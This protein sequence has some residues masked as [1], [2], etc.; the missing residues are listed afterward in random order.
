MNSHPAPGPAE[1]TSTPGPESAVG[2]DQPTLHE[3]L[4]RL[5]GD[6]AARSAFDADP[7]GVLNQ[8]G[9]G[10][11]SATD[12]LQATSL[13]LD[14]APVDVVSEYDRSVQSS[15]EKFAA[16]STQHVAIN[17][18]H[19]VHPLDEQEEPIM[20]NNSAPNFDQDGDVDAQLPSPAPQGGDTNTNIEIEQ[21]DSHNLVNVH[22]V[23][24]G[25]NIG[26]VAA[27]GNT[28]GNVVGDTVGS[29]T[30]VVGDTTNLVGD[31]TFGS[32]NVAGDLAY[33]SVE[34]VTNTVDNTVDTG[35]GLVGG[36]GTMVAGGDV[37][38]IAGGVAGDLPVV[39]DVAGVAGGLPAVGDVAGGLPVDDVAGVAGGVA[40]DLP[41][42]DLVGNVGGLAGGLPV[43][44]VAGVA[45]GVA[46]DLPVVGDV[47]APVAETASNLPVDDVAAP[48]TET[49]E[50]LPVD[51]VT[52]SLPVDDIAGDLPVVDEATEALPLDHATEA[53]PAPEELPVVGDVA[54]GAIEDVAGTATSALPLDGLL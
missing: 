18:L 34:N 19:P 38:G 40:G 3:F 43:D 2:G 37:A 42:D 4:T 48:V 35:A 29:V 47:A 25:N 26:N 32:V 30:G 45:G 41:V 50:A 13:V 15:V 33:G 5:V 36:A 46:G 44:D 20:L 24:S 31:L 54:G 7:H 1:P 6:P 12:V 14:Y 52:S 11:M 27:V 16:S 8:A 10:D 49:V 21:T 39:G 22:D 53:L 17:Q 28:V 9:F 51:D 23:L